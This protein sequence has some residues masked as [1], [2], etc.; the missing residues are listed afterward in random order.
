[1]TTASTEIDDRLRLVWLALLTFNVLL[2]LY[3]L[4][5]LFR[6]DAG[7]STHEHLVSVVGSFSGIFLCSAG[8]AKSMRLKWWLLGAAFVSIGVSFWF[9]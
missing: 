8:V 3:A 4:F 5:T 6:A 2:L 1:M 9:H 7:G